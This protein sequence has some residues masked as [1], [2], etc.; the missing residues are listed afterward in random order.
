MFKRMISVLVVVLS[1]L[2]YAIGTS[3]A[4][5]ISGS[6]M[7]TDVTPVQ[8][9]VVWGTT[10]PA[11]G[12]VNVFQDPVGTIPEP[13]AVASFESTNHPPAEDLGVMKVK[14]VGL[15]PDTEY[16][17]QTETIVKSDN[18]VYLSPIQSVK[19][20]KSSVIV[21][22]DVLALKT[23]IGNQNPAHGALIIA[24]VDDAS[25]SI[26]CWVGDG[27]PDSWGAIDTNNFYDKQTHVNLELQGGE[28]INLMLFGGSL[29]SFETQ[30]TVPPE[31][32]GMQSFKA[33]AILSALASASAAPVAADGGGGGGCFISTAFDSF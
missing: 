12:T 2:V 1:V 27:V 7:V 33:A 28:T 29:G 22:N 21:R 19:T 9:C 15:K 24:S 4:A 8:F 10:E 26:S 20:E 13:N 11:F 6:M 30:E 3:S 23:G 14:V 16:F 25:Y 5:V 18:S 17:F 32:G 31:T